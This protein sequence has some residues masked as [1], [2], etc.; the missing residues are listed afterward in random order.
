MPRLRGVF[1]SA[2]SAAY[3]LGILLVYT[4]GSVLPWRIVAAVASS[5]PISC[6]LVFFFLPESPVYLVRKKRIEAARKALIWLRGGNCF[7]VNILRRTASELL[8]NIT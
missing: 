2:Q 7:E 8:I 3:S 1:S 4:L 5:L 6:L